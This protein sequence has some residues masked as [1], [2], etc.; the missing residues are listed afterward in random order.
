MHRNRITLVILAL[1]ATLTIGFG[2][3]CDEEN[4]NEQR[5]TAIE[6]RSQTFARA[7]AAVPV[8]PNTNFPQRQSLADF[9]ARTD[10]L[11]HPWYIYILGDNGNV[12][13][14]YVAKAR[15]VNSCAF[16][17]S[18]EDVHDTGQGS[19]IVLTAPSLDGIYYGGAGASAGCDS[20]FI[21]DAST[22]AMIE[23]RG[24]KWFQSDVPLIVDAEQIKVD[25]P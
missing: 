12:I 22:D 20:W 4:Q 14:Y 10:L 16:L 11:D 24:V 23:F 19:G 15:A 5:E 3:A 2:I 18:T 1:L 13:G 6:N 25:L 17:S 7:E 21:F 9:S 8:Q